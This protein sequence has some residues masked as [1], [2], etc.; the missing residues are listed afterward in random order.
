MKFSLG[1]NVDITCQ[2]YKVQSPH[3][4]FPELLDACTSKKRR[5]C[6]KR[7]GMWCAVPLKCLCAPRQQI[8]A[9]SAPQKVRNRNKARIVTLL[10]KL[11]V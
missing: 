7:I 3:P 2:S 5:C 11:S 10:R 4:N 1:R 8:S 9:K 6:H